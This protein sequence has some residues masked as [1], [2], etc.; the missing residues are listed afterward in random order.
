MALWIDQ[1]IAGLDIPMTHAYSID[2]GQTPE[3]LI[4]IQLN[5]HKS[6]L[7]Q[8]RRNLFFFLIVLLDQ[9]IQSL[10]HIVHNQVQIYLIFLSL[11]EKYVFALREVLIP[12]FDTIG[13]I[14][15]LD[16]LML[17]I[18]VPLVL[19]DLLDGH[20]LLGLA[21]DRLRIIKENLEDFT[22]STVPDQ[23]GDDVTLS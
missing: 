2:I 17:P 18:L 16:N 22:E 10:G 15:I 14:D 1:H 5:L 12:E 13:V 11:F 23:L 19:E 3:H 8:L 7:T 9:R 4:G 20:G 21:V 6:I